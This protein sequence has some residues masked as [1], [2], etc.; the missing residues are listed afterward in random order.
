MNKIKVLLAEDHTIVRKGLKAILDKEVGIEIVG[1]AS[2]GQE[3]LNMVEEITPHIVVMDISMPTLNGFQATRR[4]TKHYSHTKVIML[5]RHHDEEYVL[6][7]LQAGASGY[8]VK[9][10]APSELITAIQSVHRGDS[11]LSPSISKIVMDHYLKQSKGREPLGKSSTLTERETEILQLIA[12]GYSTSEIA[13]S[14]HISMNTVSTH[15]THIM[16]KLDIH[17]T[18]KLTQYAIQKGII[19]TDTSS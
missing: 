19:D 4:I 11:Y 2:D 5:S 3:T 8:L 9:K 16:N 12:E 18:A 1:E 13:G 17:S 7:S 14:L 6:Q 10:S 15:R